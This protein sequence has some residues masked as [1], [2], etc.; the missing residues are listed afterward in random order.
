MSDQGRVG[1]RLC[2]NVHD[3][4]ALVGRKQ[5]VLGCRSANVKAA[6]THFQ[7]VQNQLLQLLLVD[8][9]VGGYSG[10]GTTSRTETINTVKTTWNGSAYLMLKQQAYDK[11]VKF[12]NANK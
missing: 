5:K 3:L 9:I 11:L 8:L 7:V 12:Y 10:E 6:R 1:S 2:N 4:T